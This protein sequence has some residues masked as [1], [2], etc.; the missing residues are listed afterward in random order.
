MTVLN[1]GLISLALL[2]YLL[3]SITPLAAL[4]DS[5]YIPSPRPLEGKQSHKSLL[6]GMLK[7]VSYCGANLWSHLLCNL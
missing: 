7:L 1:L 5:F 2:R 4:D 6:Q 3:W